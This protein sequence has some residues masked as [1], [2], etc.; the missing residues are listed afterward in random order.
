MTCKQLFTI[1]LVFIVGWFC[2]AHAIFW[3]LH[4]YQSSVVILCWWLLCINQPVERQMQE[5]CISECTEMHT[6]CTY[7]L[8]IM[9]VK[10]VLDVAQYFLAIIVWVHPL[11]LGDRP[12]YYIWIS[13]QYGYGANAP[14]VWLNK[15]TNERKDLMSMLL[16]NPWYHKVSHWR[17]P[18]EPFWVCYYYS[19]YFYLEPF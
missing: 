11:H 15:I 7:R 16:A 5:V 19:Y 1:V 10:E 3:T 13:Y 18:Q 17:T 9:V 4:N 14:Y 6:F 2:L 8:K 12:M